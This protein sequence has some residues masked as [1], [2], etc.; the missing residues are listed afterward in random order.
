MPRFVFLFASLYSLVYGGMHLS[1]YLKL[2]SIIG[3]G[4]VWSALYALFSVAMMMGSRM[5]WVFDFGD[6]TVLR[7]TLSL[8]CYLWM[9]Y[10]L[11]ACTIFFFTDALSLFWQVLGRLFS[12]SPTP[13]PVSSRIR[14]WIGLGGALLL[15]F[16]GWFEASTY[17]TVFLEIGTD[18]LTSGTERVRIAHISDV[19]LGWIVQEGRLARMLEAVR[20]AKPDMLVI[21]GDLVDGDMEERE[22]EV[23][24]FR[25]LQLPLGV[26][27]VTGNHEYHA[28]IDQALAFYE[29]SGIRVL[30]DE[31]VEAG[32][33]V[34]VGMDDAS[35]RRAD[36][37]GEYEPLSRGSAFTVLLKHRPTVAPGTVGH[38]D[39]QLSGHTHRG[40]IWPFYWA[41]RLVYDY[42]PGLRTL[43]DN[44]GMVYV[45][46]GIGTWGPP[47]RFL[48]PP[49]VVVID[50]VRE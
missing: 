49:E 29:R 34:L 10:L 46:N 41:T 11:L 40:Q 50:I 6:A 4:W 3:P 7:D 15:C 44:A 36:R 22:A 30:R 16:Y 26:Y 27:G 38:F 9:G 33:L 24:L 20:A 48:A 12:P 28:G 13:F 19:H 31:G 23:T 18:K 45:S 32:G 21:T 14:A 5:L 37:G 35:A 47:L 25:N 43:E 2:R 17:R 39:L 1:F 8:V 42:R